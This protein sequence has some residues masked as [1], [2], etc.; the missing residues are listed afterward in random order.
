M[1]LFSCFGP[2][3]NQI[4]TFPN[5]FILSV[6]L[7]QNRRWVIIVKTITHIAQYHIFIFVMY[8]NPNMIPIVP[9]KSIAAMPSNL[10][11]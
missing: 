11:L 10:G 9:I 6:V 2:A 7:T 4:Y 5:I 1:N 8:D 3:C